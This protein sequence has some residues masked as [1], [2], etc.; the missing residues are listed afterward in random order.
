MAAYLGRRFIGLI[1]TLLL[2]SL[3]VFTVL[4]ILPG[5][6]AQIVLGL[7]ADPAVHEATR[8]RLGL[9][10]PPITRYFDW[11][12]GALRG[13]LGASLHH[14]LPVSSQIWSG[15]TVT[16]PLTGMAIV[17]V[18]VIA[19]PLGAF[20]AT[21][22]N[23]AGDYFGRFLVQIGMIVPEFL[24]GLLLI[25]CFA[26]WLRLLPAGG[27]PGWEEGGGAMSALLLPTIALTLPRAA[28]LARMARA[29]FLEVLNEGYI[30][31]ARGKG[32]SSRTIL[33]KH[34]LR[35][36]LVPLLTLTGLLIS[37]L[38]AGTIIIENV[39][40]LHGV[41]RLAFQAIAARDLPLVQGTIVVVAFL[42]AGVNFVV[43]LLYGLLDPRIRYQ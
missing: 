4:S 5:D 27:F 3:A 39:F 15:L 17:L 26:V 8:I 32:L 7:D 31:T 1:I 43:D 18:I 29:S 21:H 19:V 13:D 24:L 25:L 6:P 33:Y 11:L 36:A 40:S 9:D 16:L 23:R 12:R 2:I 14:G 34:A 41:G 35:N 38:I 30:R 20:T 22:H 42:I 28:I 37:Q 10:R